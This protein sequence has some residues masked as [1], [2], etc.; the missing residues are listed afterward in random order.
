VVIDMRQGNRS[1]SSGFTLIEMM[2][3]VVVM[4]VLLSVAV[5]SFRQVIANQ[6]IKTA[7]FDLFSALNYA[8]SEAIKR[9]VSVSMRAGESADGAWSTGWRIV[10]SSNNLLRSWGAI[11]SL[12]VSNTAAG[13]ATVL[14]F[15]SD[16]RL[17]NAAAPKLQIQPATSISGVSSR[18]V[19]ITLSGRPTTQMGSCP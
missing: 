17:T 4:V 9:N 2:V 14:T 7:S 8:R 1:L 12:T 11:S 6:R 3:V 19:Q 5:P 13:N 18:C 16:G 15:G 10:D